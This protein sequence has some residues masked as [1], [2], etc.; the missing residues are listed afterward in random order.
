MAKRMQNWLEK[1]ALLE[2]YHKEHGNIDIPQSYEVNSIKLG[3]WLNN[4]R[5]AYKGNGTHKIT[6]EQIKLM[7]ML[8][9]NW[10]VKEDDWNEKYRLL[11]QYYKEHGDID[12]PDNY[13]ING[14]NLGSWLFRQKQGYKGNT[15]Y[16]MT[17]ERAN[18]LNELEIESEINKKSWMAKYKLLKEYYQKHGNIH[19]P[20][21]YVINGIQLGNWLNTQKQAYRGKGNLKITNE[22]IRLLNELEINWSIRDKKLLN[23]EITEDNRLK[24]NVI[25]LDS[26]KHILEDLRNENINEISNNERQEE[27]EEIVIKR[28]FR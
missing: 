20:R 18:L 7:D 9:M 1:Y 13:E 4:Q 21:S 12:I 24:Y 10:E 15:N 27:I 11:E 23:G 22:Q 3:H 19:I 6:D 17:E 16:K 2:E 26:I 8:G 25:L 14:I 5:Q 28:L